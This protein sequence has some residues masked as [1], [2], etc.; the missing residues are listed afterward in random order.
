MLKVKFLGTTITSKGRFEKGDE[1]SFPI[2]EAKDLQR[3]K[4]VESP[5]P[6]VR[7]SK[8]KVVED[9]PKEDS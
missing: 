6:T 7:K 3:L 4:S 9:E 8:K 5:A 2:D 1:I